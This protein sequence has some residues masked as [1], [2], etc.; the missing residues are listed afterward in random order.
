MSAR[1]IKT[2]RLVMRP[3]NNDED[4]TM[5]KQSLEPCDYFFQFGYEYDEHLLDGYDF[6]SLGVICYSVFLKDTSE[7]IGYAGIKPDSDDPN[8]GELEYFIARPHRNKGYCREAAAALIGAFKDGLLTGTK[9]IELYAETIDENVASA[10]V[11]EKLGFRFEHNLMT[12]HLCP[13]S[14]DPDGYKTV[15]KSV[16]VYKLDL[17]SYYPPATVL[18]FSRLAHDDQ[19]LA[20]A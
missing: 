4:L 1:M 14:T 5:Y 13:D 8:I 9:G 15:G 17:R 12:L 10:R 11:L 7:Y 20:C 2:D 16:S 6:T 19:L 18:A 3:A